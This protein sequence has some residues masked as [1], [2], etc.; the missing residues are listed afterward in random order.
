MKLDQFQPYSQS[1]KL[2]V[3]DYS[4]C[5][6]FNTLNFAAMQFTEADIVQATDN[7]SEKLGLEGFGV[8]YLGT[9]EWIWCGSEEVNS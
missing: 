7:F 6:V 8:V 5:A 2:L 3:Y 9:T 4:P 1:T